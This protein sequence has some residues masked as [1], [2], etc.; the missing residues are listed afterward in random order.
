MGIRTA[1]TSLKDA[2][3]LGPPP[4]GNLAVPV[5]AKGSLIVELY[6]PRGRDV[7]QPHTRDE[8]YVVAQGSALFWDGTDTEALALGSFV[9]VAAGQEHRFERCSDD[10]AVW[11]LFYGPEGGEA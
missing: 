4:A 2:L 5:F 1:H 9:Y 7:Q 3:A 11:V 8:V 10:F 6:S